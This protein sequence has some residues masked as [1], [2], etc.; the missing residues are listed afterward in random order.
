MATNL[1]RE[2]LQRQLDVLP[3]DILAEVADFTAFILA[4]RNIPI[5]Y[6]DWTQREWQSFTLGQFLRESDSD[7][8]YTLE[9][10]EEVYG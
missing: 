7:V 2:Q 8:E 1:L 9:D 4:R 3:D 5:I 10:A 6:S